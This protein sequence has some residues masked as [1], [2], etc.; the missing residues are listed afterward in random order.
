MLSFDCLPRR[1]IVV[2]NLERDT[3]A[4]ITLFG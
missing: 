3:L 1:Q 2:R 4:A